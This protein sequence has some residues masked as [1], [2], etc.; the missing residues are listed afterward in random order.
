VAIGIVT[1]VHRLEHFCSS[2]SADMDNASAR[3][4]LH[5]D[6]QTRFPMEKNS[7][8]WIKVRKYRTGGD[9]YGVGQKKINLGDP[10]DSRS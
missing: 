9:A 8:S 1:T 3:P 5:S 7:A 4:L 6:L 2:V 10:P